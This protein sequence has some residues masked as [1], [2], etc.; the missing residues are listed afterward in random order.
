MDSCH[1]TNRRSWSGLLQ[2]SDWHNW[3]EVAKLGGCWRKLRR[4]WKKRLGFNHVV[5][6]RS[7]WE[8][9]TLLHRLWRP[10]KAVFPFHKDMQP[11][12]GS[13]HCGEEWVL[14]ALGRFLS[15]RWRRLEKREEARWDICFSPRQ[16][17]KT[18]TEKMTKGTE[19]K[20]QWG[21]VLQGYHPWT[22]SKDMEIKVWRLF[23]G[24]KLLGRRTSLPE[25]SKFDGQL[26]EF[27]GECWG[28]VL[29]AI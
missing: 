4:S 2:C 28:N 21:G 11:F 7:C 9:Q 15:S 27:H 29:G 19:T 12:S 5:T 14:H 24:F 16:V 18:Q 3:E 1:V 17:T 20:E 10:R 26:L 6:H 25:K 8:I 22:G 13:Q 23:Q